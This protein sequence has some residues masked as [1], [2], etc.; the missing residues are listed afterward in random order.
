M[1]KKLL[2]YLRSDGSPPR[3]P[4]VERDFRLAWAALVWQTMIVDGVLQKSEEARAIG[5]LSSGLG[6]DVGQAE[7]LIREA[8]GMNEKEELKPLME[9][10]VESVSKEERERILRSILEVANA[11]GAIELG[12]AAIFDFVS[13]RFGVKL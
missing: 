8:S 9:A 11:D 6:I 10:V 2:G 1:L 13:K 3:T 12:E 4:E 7:D 5:T